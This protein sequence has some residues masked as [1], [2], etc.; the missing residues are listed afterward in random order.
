M[1]HST[2]GTRGAV[3]CKRKNCLAAGKENVGGQGTRPFFLLKNRLNRVGEECD[4]GTRGEEPRPEKWKDLGKM[5]FVQVGNSKKHSDF[6][7]NLVLR[8]SA[9][10]SQAN[11]PSKPAQEL[12]S[13]VGPSK[14]G[15]CGRSEKIQLQ[16][17]L[18][19]GKRNGDSGGG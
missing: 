8:S 14:S 10:Q 16:A 7:R 4:L 18:H 3:A 9:R 6:L 12:F 17:I 2:G 1:K 13:A 19:L 15:E 5:A 11:P